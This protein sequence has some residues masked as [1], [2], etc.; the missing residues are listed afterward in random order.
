M[1]RC[2]ESS[3]RS[4][5]PSVRHCSRCLQP[6]HQATPKPPRGSKPTSAT[7][8]RSSPL[9]APAE[10][11]RRWT[12]GS[13]A[14]TAGSPSSSASPTHVGA[15]GMVPQSHDGESKKTPMGIFTLDFAFGTQPNPGG[16]LQ[17][18]QVTRD[19]WWDGD[20]KKPPHLQHHAGLQEGR[21]PP[22]RHRPGQRH[23]EPLHPAVRP[24][25]RDGRQ[26]GSRPPA[27]A[28]LS[29]STPPTVDPPPAVSPSTTTPSSRSCAGFSPARSSPSR[30][31]ASSVQAVVDSAAD[32]RR[33]AARS[34]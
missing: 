9:S 3:S 20:M 29:L 1:N 14:P 34:T 21:L 17:Y 31:D 27:T 25:D 15:N 30:N 28:A 5:L 24:R 7:P 2:A 12:S 19:H 18:V 8:P 23:R 13:A 4:V 11:P 22:L 10:P 32:R 26:Q 33:R 16:G 6:P